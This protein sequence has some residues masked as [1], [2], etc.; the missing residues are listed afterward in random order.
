M[1]AS[2]QFVLRL[3]AQFL[4]QQEGVEKSAKKLH[5]IRTMAEKTRK[6]A[7]DHLAPPTRPANTDSGG[8]DGYGEQQIL[9]SGARETDLVV[10]AVAD[11]WWNIERDARG[12]FRESIPVA[13]QA[14]APSRLEAATARATLELRHFE[15]HAASRTRLLRTQQDLDAEPPIRPVALAMETEEILRDVVEKLADRGHRSREVIR[16]SDRAP[17]GTE[18]CGFNRHL[19]AVRRLRFRPDARTAPLRV[20]QNLVSFVDLMKPLRVGSRADIGMNAEDEPAIRALD[21]WEAGT[22]LDAQ[23]RV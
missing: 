20:G 11:T 14:H 9:D 1:T 18:R 2:V 15:W 22:L 6:L 3:R 23:D 5:R 13:H 17:P 8:E 7:R 19:P 16:N 21:C 12:S 4:D 10:L